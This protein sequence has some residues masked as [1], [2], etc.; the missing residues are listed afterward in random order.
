M[1]RKF[2]VSFNV[3]SLFTNLV[4]EE[5]T[6]LAVNYIAEGNPDLKLGKPELSSLFTIAT[7]ARPTSHSTVLYDQID[8]VALGTPLA[9][10]LRGIM[11]T[12]G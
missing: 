12:H 5:C 8:G 3:E 2:V 4:P 1:S 7:S 9:I 10:F 11:K 6:D